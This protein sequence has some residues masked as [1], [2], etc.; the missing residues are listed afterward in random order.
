MR[1]FYSVGIAFLILV[2]QGYGEE[3]S[4]Y[5]EKNIEGWTILLHQDLEKT[6]LSEKMFRQLKSQFYQIK[7]LV[8][9]KKVKWLQTVKIYCDVK[10]PQGMFTGLVYHPSK[11]WLLENGYNPMYARSVHMTSVKRFIE[12][13]SEKPSWLIMHELSHAYHHQVVGHDNADIINAYKKALKNKH[14][15]NATH[16]R[17]KD[18]KEAYALKSKSE[19]FAELT[20][21]YFGVNDM[22]PF[23]RGE[24]KK[25]DPEGY[26]VLK[27]I[28]ED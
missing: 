14:Y 11:K 23:V 1:I 3:K 4:K 8:P 7:L 21:A 2:T 15:K 6:E 28:W 10:D 24:L 19:Y 13:T 20:E 25:S 9:E 22:F 27:K 16:I 26:N 18:W 5:I 12:S 17:R